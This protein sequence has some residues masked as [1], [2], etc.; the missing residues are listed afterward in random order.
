MC[1]GDADAMFYCSG[2]LQLV[3]L[4]EMKYHICG[5]SAFLKGDVKPNEREELDPY[6]LKV[7]LLHRHIVD[8]SKLVIPTGSCW[9]L[10]H[11]TD[12]VIANE[13]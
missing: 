6:K 9:E 2:K 7:P 3:I 12:G 8:V 5:R 13:L 1:K 11:T 10:P 4:A